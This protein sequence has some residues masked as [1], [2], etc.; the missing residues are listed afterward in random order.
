MTENNCTPYTSGLMTALTISGSLMIVVSMIICLGS[1]LCLNVCHDVYVDAQT[2]DFDV[3][4]SKAATSSK[5]SRD[6][7]HVCFKFMVRGIVTIILTEIGRE[8]L[9]L[10]RC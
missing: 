6:L 2:S 8:L 7:L 9:H 10:V 1:I 3:E 4:R 5:K